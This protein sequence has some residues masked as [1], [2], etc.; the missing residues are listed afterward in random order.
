MIEKDRKYINF[1]VSEILSSHLLKYS[2]KLFEK[3]STQLHAPNVQLMHDMH[4][5]IEN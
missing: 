5:I 2:C 3:N 1:F 4:D